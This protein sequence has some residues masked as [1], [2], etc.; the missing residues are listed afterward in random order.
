MKIL[1]N[2]S[3]SGFVITQ[4]SPY[5]QT[6]RSLCTSST[7]DESKLSSIIPLLLLYWPKLTTTNNWKEAWEQ[8]GICMPFKGEY[9][10][11]NYFE[12][13]IKRRRERDYW[14]TI[15]KKYNLNPSNSSIGYDDLINTISFTA[16]R[17]VITPVV[18]CY[19]YNSTSMPLNLYNCVNQ[20]FE[21]NLKHIHK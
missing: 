5:N 8:N 19:N 12:Q 16:S 14:E 13:V 18:D 1:T 2:S 9:N 17:G 6:T 7:Y 15:Q 3:Q 11:L 4:F 20:D 10:Q 21:V